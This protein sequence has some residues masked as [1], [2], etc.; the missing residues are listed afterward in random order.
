ML[1]SSTAVEVLSAYTY[2]FTKYSLPQFEF[3]SLDPFLVYIPG[4]LKFIHSW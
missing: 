4:K 3:Y 1:K 2:S